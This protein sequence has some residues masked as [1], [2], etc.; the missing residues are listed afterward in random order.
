MFDR[1]GTET[2]ALSQS[3][4]DLTLRAA[5]QPEMLWDEEEWGE[6]QGDPDADQG[7]EQSVPA[8]IREP[9]VVTRTALSAAWAWTIRAELMRCAM[10]MAAK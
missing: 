4:E 5:Q 6:H 3:G 8:L 10:T 2:Q 1:R 7:L 9:S